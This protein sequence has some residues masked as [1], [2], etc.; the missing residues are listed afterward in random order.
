MKLY[1]RNPNQIKK[2]Q[3]DFDLRHTHRYSTIS[4]PSY[5]HIPGL[6]P[7]PVADEKGHSYGLKRPK[8]TELTVTNWQNNEQYLFSIDLFNYAYF[9]EAHEH[10]EEFWKSS[11]NLQEKIFIQGLIQLSAAYLK[12]VQGFDDGFHKLTSKGLDKICLTEKNFTRLFGINLKSIINENKKFINSYNKA[13]SY[14]PIITLLM[15]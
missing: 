12:W 7:H 13:N 2:I 3:N 14:P 4:F 15:D 8:I 6:T 5:K 9:W 10:L 1:T 11:I